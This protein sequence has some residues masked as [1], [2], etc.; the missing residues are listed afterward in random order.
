M[1]KKSIFILYLIF[2]GFTNLHAQNGKNDSVVSAPVYD[3]FCPSTYDST[4]ADGNVQ[5]KPKFFL[6]VDKYFADSI[7]YP[8]DAKEE[9][10]EATIYLSAIIEKDGSVSHVTV[11]HSYN[12]NLS[13]EAERVVS[14]M[15]KWIP[16]VQNGVVVR[17]QTII[18]V[19]FNLPTTS[20]DSTIKH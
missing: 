11:I 8:E 15:P 17:V 19:R 2:I 20:A 18:P 10:I 14:T 3:C 1:K 12:K 7:R 4:I 5:I 16:G 9:K 13:A 6:D